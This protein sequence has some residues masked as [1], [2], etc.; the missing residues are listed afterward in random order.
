MTRLS[1]GF[2]TVLT[3]LVVA[4]LTLVAPA[5]AAPLPRDVALAAAPRWVDR[6]TGTEGAADA[7]SETGI[8]DVLIDDQ[9]HVTSTCEHYLRRVRKI[10]SAAGVEDGAEIELTFDPSHE[11]IVLHGL[12]IL[13]GSARIDAVRTSTIRTFDSEDGREHQIY[14]GS[15]RVVFLLADLRP[16]DVVDFEA[17]IIGQNPVFGGR[18]SRHFVLAASTRHAVKRRVRVLSP[19][20]R[21]LSFRLENTTTAATSRM[22]GAESEWLWEKANVQPYKAEEGAPDWFDGRP[23]VSI[24]EYASWAEVAQ[25]ASGLYEKT[26]PPSAALTAKIA[27]IR[28]A[29][30]TDTA[31]AE[32]V[33][34][35]VQ[36]EI[37]YLGIDLGEHSHRPHS[38]TA[39][40]EQRFGDCKDKVMLL[41]TMLRALGIEATPALVDTN[42]GAHIDS[43]LPSPQ[44]FD[45]VIAKLRV[46]GREIWVDPTRTLERGPLASTEVPLGRALLASRD[47][48]NLSIIPTAKLNQPTAVVRETLRVTDGGGTLETTSTYRG[49]SANDMRYTLSRTPRSKTKA[50]NLESYAKRFPGIEASGEY[51]VEDNEKTNVLVTREHYAMPHPINEGVISLW[52]Y[53]LAPTVAAPTVTKRTSPL[54]LGPPSFVRHEVVIEGVAVVLPKSVAFSDRALTFKMNTEARANGGTVT[55]EL[56]THTDSVPVADVPSHLETITSIRD[57]L[58]EDAHVA[59]PEPAKPDAGNTKLVAWVMLGVLGFVF[60]SVAVITAA[61]V[62]WSA[63]RRI[64]WRPVGPQP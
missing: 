43:E 23:T 49:A 20:S 5:Y 41:V 53:D 52:A 60:L 35:F 54:D 56:Q 32:A 38:A 46:D 24:S 16:G 33:V 36:D 39:V 28:G 44:A 14:D 48:T 21:P 27:E 62:A 26:P 42:L 47:V 59:P 45:H 13:R 12:H 22:V 61:L 30:A 50:S 17:S 9:L 40:F 64:R 2:R 58:N 3:A 63:G 31:R 6:S 29:H 4:V 8:A 7:E 57:A 10:T 18:V 25:W 1:L 19:S 55:Y 37:R 51:V 11:R 34:R 15:R